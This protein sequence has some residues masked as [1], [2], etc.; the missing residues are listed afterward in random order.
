MGLHLIHPDFCKW[1]FSIASMVNGVV[2]RC[3]SQLK[4]WN[5][6]LLVALVLSICLHLLVIVMITVDH[7][8]HQ[9][10]AKK[11][12]EI[13]DV[14]LFKQPEKPKLKQKNAQAKVIANRTLKGAPPKQQH[15]KRTRIARAP[16]PS[17]MP[18]PAPPSVPKPVPRPSVTPP[19]PQPKFKPRP[20]KQHPS[21]KIKPHRVVQP[22]R[23]RVVRHK[24]TP[25]PIPLSRL[26]SPAS[27]FAQPSPRRSRAQQQPSLRREANIP[28]NT[29]EVKY[30]PYAHALV[31]A[32]E[33]QWR[34]G[35]A[36]YADHPDRDRQVLMRLSIDRDGSLAGVEI[37]RPSPIAGLNSSAVQAIHDAAPFRPLPSSWGLDRASFY[38]TFEV[39]D[40]GF[41]FHGM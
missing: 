17:L 28:I 36:D 35:Q 34:P 26:L 19:Q 12:P 8:D 14:V 9:S 20:T 30:A 7:H 15:D 5:R 38:L 10:K 40:G 33:E 22:N 37:L 24:P 23:K 6:P 21:K 27:P 3:W 32:L 25:R 39:V 4:Q 31:N 16:L 29:R 1:L 41:V 13:M 11:R 2:H 18:K